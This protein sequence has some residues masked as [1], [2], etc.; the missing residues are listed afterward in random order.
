V[1][2]SPF[3]PHRSERRNAMS[4]RR[5][6]LVAIT[7]S[8]AA[9]VPYL[10]VLLVLWRSTPNA[11]PSDVSGPIYDTQGRAILHGHLSLASGSIPNEAFLHGG[12]TYTYFGIF[13]SLIRIP[14]LLFTHSLDGRLTVVSIG[15]SWLVTALFA[16]LLL[17]R[18]RVVVRADAPLGWAEAVS[19]GLLLASI[20]VGSVLVILASQ[21]EVYSED[22]AWSVALTC[23]SLFAILGVVERPSWGRVAGNGVLVL[24]ANL[25]RSTTGY[26][27]ILGTVLIAVWFASGRA[28]PDRRR[29]ALPLSLTGV[30]A[31]AV[32]SAI[33]FAKFHLLFG[34]RA[35]EQRLYRAFGLSHINGGHYF[36]I[37][38]LPDTLRAYVSPGNLRITRL[39]P[40]VTFPDIPATPFGKTHLFLRALTSSAVTTMPLLVGVGVWGVI[41]AFQR[42]QGTPL[43]SLRILVVAMAASASAVMVF[44]WIAE[45]YVAD[46]MPLLVLVGMVGM[47]DIWRRLDGRGR[48]LRIVAPALIGVLALFGFVANL[49][50]AVIPNATW[51]Q[52]QLAHF[53]RAQLQVSDLTGHPMAKAIVRGAYFPPDAPVAQVFVMGRCRALYVSDS[54]GLLTT[55]FLPELTWRLVERAPDT[56]ICHSLVGSTGGLATP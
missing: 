50:M 41:A 25:D 26:A 28:G 47:V 42:Q 3:D 24:L 21:P 23:G 33:D 22:L 6:R 37:R 35:S 5:Y 53:V 56:P 46:F 43:R 13:P 2:D 48:S 19:Y 54:G 20:L 34:F 15:T 18:V 45:R 7:A 38:F 31:L 9:A 1:I 10:W 52:T 4:V 12:R 51:T 16:A 14:A 39:F 30:G 11:F 29:W 32:G 27:C 49:G 44:G 17:W 55:P 36:G 40:F 8:A